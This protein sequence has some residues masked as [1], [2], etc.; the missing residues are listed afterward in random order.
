M[1]ASSSLGILYIVIL[2]QFLDLSALRH[3]FRKIKGVILNLTNMSFCSIFQV[4]MMD[5]EW[6]SEIDRNSL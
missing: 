5:E 3:V 1:D 6:Y 2:N 4:P